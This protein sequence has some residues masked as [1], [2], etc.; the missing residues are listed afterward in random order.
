MLFVPMGVMMPSRPPTNFFLKMKHTFITILVLQGAIAICRFVALDVWGAISDAIVVGIG[1]FA[2]TDSEIMYT[3]L[4]GIS[5]SCNFFFDSVNLVVRVTVLKSDFFNMDMP[6]MHNARSFAIIAATVMA[7]LGAVLAYCL[8][9][10]FRRTAVEEHHPLMGAG[11]FMQP[12][13]AGG[14]MGYGGSY[15]QGAPLGGY[16][17]GSSGGGPGAAGT[18][19][20][21]SAFT[22]PGH[23]LDA[24]GGFSRPGTD[25]PL[26]PLPNAG[27][28]EPVH[29]PQS[30]E[31]WNVP[32]SSVALARG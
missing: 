3:I 27:G 29:P 28:L 11:P 12:P 5:C 7:C 6:F 25:Y 1:Y 2:V 10:D 17:P 18:A 19:A 26:P 8:Y 9:K 32:G 23:R 20:A 16:P 13:M 21:F 24:A 22:G 31:V 15:G 30:P 14:S 4:Y